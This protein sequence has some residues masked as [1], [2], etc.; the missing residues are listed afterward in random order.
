VSLMK[1]AQ[2]RARKVMLMSLVAGGSNLGSM[3][4]Q[5]KGVPFLG[6]RLSIP[7]QQFARVNLLR[8]FSGV[9]SARILYDC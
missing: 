2:I 4:S 8:L 1:I 7:G 5:A 9:L 3:T 6:I